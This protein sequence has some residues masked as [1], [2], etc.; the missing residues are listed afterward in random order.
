MAI[1]WKKVFE[2]VKQTGERCFVADLGSEEIFVIL[3]L[4]SY[5][6]LASGPRAIKGLSEDQLMD[7]I[8]RDIDYWQ[9]AQEQSE[10]G[11]K[12][13]KSLI[14]AEKDIDEDQYYI[15]PVA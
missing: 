8:N 3:D 6:Q 9:A 7:K 5:E 13:E 1:D 15:E 10:E 12:D 14:S 2:L 11:K 4:K